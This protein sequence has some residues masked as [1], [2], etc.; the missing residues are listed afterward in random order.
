MIIDLKQLLWLCPE[1][2][3]GH[4]RC[5]HN[6]RKVTITQSESERL[7]L[8]CVLHFTKRNHLRNYQKCLSFFLKKLILFLRYSKFCTHLFNS[9]SVIVL[10]FL[11]EFELKYSITI[12][13]NDR[14]FY[15]EMF[16][17]KYAKKSA[18]ET[19]EAAFVGVNLS[20]SATP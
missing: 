9:L 6:I 7:S 17:G 2:F 3:P 5:P 19:I 13:W 20:G 10:N 8:L 12:W 11:A 14:L 18:P 1:F 4:H 16:M 15:L